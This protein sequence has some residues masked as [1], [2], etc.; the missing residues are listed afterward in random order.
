MDGFGLGLLLE[1]RQVKRMISSYVG[2]NAEFERQ[3]LSGELEVELTPQVTS[4]YIHS[5]NLY[6]IY[7]ANIPNISVFL[8]Q[9]TLAEQVELGCL[10][11]LPPRPTGLWS[12]EEELPS[13]TTA[14]AASKLPV[15][16]ERWAFL[17]RR[18]G[19]L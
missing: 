14:E 15:N 9:G 1:G 5:V 13:N 3:F 2:E 10:P 7:H 16:P 18:W 19:C 17:C 11:S 6:L 8:L 12:T 4:H